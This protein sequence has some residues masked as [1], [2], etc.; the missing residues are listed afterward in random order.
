MGAV[1]G[2]LTPVPTMREMARKKSSPPHRLPG[3]RYNYRI[4]NP[5]RLDQAREAG[6]DPSRGFLSDSFALLPAL[7]L[8]RLD[9]FGSAVSR[10]PLPRSCARR[11]D[12]GWVRSATGGDLCSEP[13]TSFA[14]TSRPYALSNTLLS[15]GED[16]RS[17][18]RTCLTG[19]TVMP[20]LD[21]FGS[22]GRISSRTSR[23]AISSVPSGCLA[24]KGEG[25]MPPSWSRRA[26]L[27]GDGAGE[28]KSSPVRTRSSNEYR[29]PHTRLRMRAA[30]SSPSE[31]S[32]RR[33]HFQS[34]SARDRREAS[35]IV[36]GWRRR[37]SHHRRPLDQR[38]SALTESG[39][40][41]ARRNCC[42]EHEHVDAAQ[43][44]LERSAV[45]SSRGD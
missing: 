44:L 43:T 38:V 18:R 3:W 21:P 28:T 12:C 19:D 7:P 30:I 9:S 32:P 24:W 8:Q 45:R 1:Q 27:L 31:P 14:D 16:S 40:L 10:P 11:S 26:T 35:Q 41:F 2:R 39:L 15:D 42:R 4:G 37:R 13:F 6:E 23:S 20:R 17:E 5:T 29:R 34:A 36:R 33:C 22:C 25:L